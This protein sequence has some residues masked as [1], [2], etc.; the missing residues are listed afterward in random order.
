MNSLNDPRIGD[1]FKPNSNDGAYEGLLEGDAANIQGQ[2]DTGWSFL[3]T[4][5]FSP[6][7]SVFLLTGTESNFLQAEA[8][9]RGFMSGSASTF[10]YAGIQAS[11][12]EWAN[13]SSDS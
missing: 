1:F 3:G 12:N 11:W 13:S 4:E 8:I 9:A 2:A 5:V 7:A 6:T 10:Y